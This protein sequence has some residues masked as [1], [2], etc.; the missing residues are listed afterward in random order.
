MA[1]PTP[2]R[3]AHKK[4]LDLLER[5]RQALEAERPLAEAIR[6]ETERAMVRGFTFLTEKPV[7][8][9]LNVDEAHAGDP[10]GAAAKWPALGRPLVALAASL[11]AEIGQLPADE[12]PA[13]IQ[14]MGLKRFHTPDV[15]RAVHQALDR[16]TVF[17]CGPNE[18]TA[19]SLPRGSTALDVAA[20]VHT[21]MASGFIRAEVIRFDHLKA[22]GSLKDARAAGHYRVEGRD[23]IVQDG[24][25]LHIHF[26]H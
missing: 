5:L 8:M 23:F 17:T 14:E 1:R 13:F 18:V 6:S 4:E 22:A 16:M 10:G 25:I 11:E 20:D 24:D 12:R 9:V 7:L 26:S 15:L 2:D 19:R 3:E 21:D